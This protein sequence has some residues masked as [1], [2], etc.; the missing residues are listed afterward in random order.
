MIGMNRSGTI[1]VN[2]DILPGTII[3]MVPLG[4]SCNPRYNNI[5]GIVRRIDPVDQRLV[6]TPTKPIRGENTIRDVYFSL[7]KNIWG[8]IILNSDWDE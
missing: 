4:D 6:V 8:Y 3:R 7:A 1:S 5:E 2:L